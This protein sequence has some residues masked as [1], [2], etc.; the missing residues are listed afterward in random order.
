MEIDQ[1]A[2]NTSAPVLTLT[3]LESEIAT[4]ISHEVIRVAGDTISVDSEGFEV[5]VLYDPSGPVYRPA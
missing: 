3:D 1:V 5:P 2:G 4:R